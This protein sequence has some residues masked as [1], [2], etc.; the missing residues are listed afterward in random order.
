MFYAVFQNFSGK[1]VW[2]FFAARKA[3]DSKWR[4]DNQDYTTDIDIK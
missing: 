2:L 3:V 1:L 4:Q